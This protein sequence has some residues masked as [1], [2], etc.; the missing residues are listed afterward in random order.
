MLQVVPPLI[1]CNQAFHNKA[2]KHQ[3]ACVHW[4]YK[5]WKSHGPPNVWPG[6]QDV[7]GDLCKGQAKV[8]RCSPRVIGV[9]RGHASSAF[10]KDATAVALKARL[11]RETYTSLPRHQSAA[12]TINRLYFPG[13][14]PDD[15]MQ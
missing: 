10:A 15:R 11:S 13:N 14:A 6:D 5:V 12:C 7:R 2:V 9:M 1:S 3:K 4:Q 8:L